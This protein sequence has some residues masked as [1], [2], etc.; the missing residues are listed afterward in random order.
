MKGMWHARARPGA[1]WSVLLNVS[2][3]KHDYI[4]FMDEDLNGFRESKPLMK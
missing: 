3:K 4:R 1:M 2:Y